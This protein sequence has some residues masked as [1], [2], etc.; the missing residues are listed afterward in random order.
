MRERKNERR[1][2]E[3]NYSSSYSKKEIGDNTDYY[4][5]KKE[6]FDVKHTARRFNVVFFVLFPK[7]SE[8]KAEITNIF[9]KKKEGKRKSSVSLSAS[10]SSAAE[11]TIDATAAFFFFS[12]SRLLLFALCV[13][14]LSFC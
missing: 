12:S 13:A 7:R 4:A 6:K 10:S 3:K 5:K 14:S 2:R 9:S 1:K 8:K 11:G